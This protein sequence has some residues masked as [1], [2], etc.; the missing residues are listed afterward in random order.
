MMTRETIIKGMTSNVARQIE[1]NPG[2]KCLRIRTKLC[3]LNDLIYTIEDGRLFCYVLDEDGMSGD[4]AGS[5][6]N[7]QLL[8]FADELMQMAE[9]AYRRSY[10]ST[11]A[12]EVQ[13]AREEMRRVL[14]NK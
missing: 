3:E 8:R 6:S 7:G 5:L 11:K 4:E 9:R 2:A 14:T 1:S 10:Q 13:Q 12:R